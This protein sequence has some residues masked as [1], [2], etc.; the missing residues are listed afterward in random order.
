MN[1]VLAFR[2]LRQQ[3]G[4]SAAVVATLALGLGATTAIFSVASAVLLRPLLA[5]ALRAAVR[6]EDPEQAIAS[7][8]TLEE[9][10]AGSVAPQSFAA[11]LLAGFALL[12]L[13]LTAVGVD[14]VASHVAGQ[15]TRELGSGW[16]WERGAASC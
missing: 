4:F 6:A 13:S 16:P 15:R 8:R 1:L 14:G 2:R 7:V 11:A 5:G 10:R 12:A 9:V 3:P